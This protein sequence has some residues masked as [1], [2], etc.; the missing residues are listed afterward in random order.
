MGATRTVKGATMLKHL[1]KLTIQQLNTLGVGALSDRPNSNDVFGRSEMNA[2]ALK[3][4]FDNVP[5]LLINK[6]NAIID[7]L[8]QADAAEYIRIA[9]DTSGVTTLQDLVDSFGNGTFATI[10]KAHP[11]ASELTTLDTI[12]DIVNDFAQHFASLD[13]DVETLQ[14]DSVD[15]G[16]ITL[17]MT[18]DNVFTMT[19]KNAVGDD[20]SKV[21]YSL[22]LTCGTSRLV[23]GCVVTAKLGDGAVTS[24]K[25]Y[26]ASVTTEKLADG[27]ATTGKIADEAVTNAKLASGSV[28]DGKIVNEAVR[29]RHIQDGAV[30]AGKIGSSAVTE[31]KINVGAIIESKLASALKNK[32]NG[33]VVG[34][35]FAPST[36]ILTLTTNGGSEI[37]IDLPTELIV[38]E[39]SYYDDTPGEE[40]IVL[41]LA[42]GDEIRIPITQLLADI[43]TYIDG[44]RKRIFDLQEAP[45]LASLADALL[46]VTPT[47]AQLADL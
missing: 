43:Y 27:A 7:L 22:D 28:T 37:T 21:T 9:L 39:G 12:Q 32:I 41:V 47:L 45:P 10:M 42:N 3:Q 1:D 16:H 26:P 14:D 31:P 11:S 24:A 6:V 33:A 34:A 18:S 2:H 30:T 17:A 5:K 8:G 40:A 19:F 35:S 44:I 20:D 13:D 23:D 15:L 4:W 25:I 38:G 36:G 29:E 46:L